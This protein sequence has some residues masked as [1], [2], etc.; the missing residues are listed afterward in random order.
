MV[1][2]AVLFYAWL[3]VIFNLIVDVML[4]WMDPKQKFE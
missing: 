2:G 1:L 3:I 4:V